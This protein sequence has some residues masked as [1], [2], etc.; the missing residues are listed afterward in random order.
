MIVNHRTTR[1]DNEL[2]L[3]IC[4]K[5]SVKLKAMINGAIPTNDYDIKWYLTDTD[6]YT[7]R[8]GTGD[9]IYA[10]EWGKYRF[11]MKY[12]A[13]GCTE[14]S[15]LTANLKVNYPYEW[16]E[17]SYVTVDTTTGKNMV[18]WDKSQYNDN[19]QYFKIYKETSTG[20]KYMK[21]WTVF[22][23]LVLCM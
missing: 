11:E 13:S 16:Q 3:Q 12:L 23:Q 4:E 19:T 14:Q 21:E 15:K 5:D 22:L 9:S 6:D 1:I 2:D 17:I 20:G 10:K 18:V 8:I 7:Y